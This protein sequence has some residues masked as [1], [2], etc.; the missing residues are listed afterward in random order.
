MRWV[1]TNVWEVSIVVQVLEFPAVNRTMAGPYIT[2][3]RGAEMALAILKDKSPCDGVSPFRPR[4]IDTVQA[5]AGAANFALTG[6]V[7]TILSTVEV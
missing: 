7:K 6:T 4:S 5:S 1:D 2:S 3:M